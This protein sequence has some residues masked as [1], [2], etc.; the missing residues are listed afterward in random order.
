MAKGG[1]ICEIASELDISYTTARRT[2]ETAVSNIAEAIDNN[3]K[4]R[5]LS[6]YEQYGDC[7]SVRR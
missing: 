3:L 6:G 2:I 5:I 7:F 1:K 4:A